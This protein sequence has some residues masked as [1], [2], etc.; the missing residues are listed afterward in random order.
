MKSEGGMLLY[1]INKNLDVTG[2]YGEHIGLISPYFIDN[3]LNAVWPTS[4]C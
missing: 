2:Q 4:E 1:S 3:F